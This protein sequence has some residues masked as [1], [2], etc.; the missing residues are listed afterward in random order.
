MY[1]VAIPDIEF[2]FEMPEGVEE[3]SQ[4]Q[5]LAFLDILEQ[6]KAGN[7]DERWL[8]IQMLYALS[9]IQR[10][11]K[12]LSSEAA[13]NLMSVAN[14]FDSYLEEKELDGRMVRVP[15]V[16][17][18]KSLIRQFE[19]GGVTWC[20]P[21]DAMSGATFQEFLHALFAFREYHENRQGKDLVRLAAVLYRRKVDI[22]E[23]HPDW[24]GSNRSAYNPNQNASNIKIL[25]T[26]PTAYLMAG[27]Y[28]MAALQEFILDTPLKI[29]GEEIHL[30]V[31]FEGEE[32]TPATSLPGL[33]W[34]DV[35]F[36]LSRSGEL[37][38][39]EKV[40]RTNL[41]EVFALLYSIH[42]ENKEALAKAKM[43]RNATVH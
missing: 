16:A 41:Y 3:M 12:P 13:C 33:G 42:R 5:Y 24:P 9:P 38:N 27:Y 31:L 32:K 11:D 37:G 29:A 2:E 26:L 39:K 23:D 28:F 1:L 14:L 34:L 40:E 4:E 35:L 15:R 30:K 8:K 19:W 10:G 21:D 20:G 43:N 17:T 22:K 6:M 25:Q 7:H 36:A 18:A